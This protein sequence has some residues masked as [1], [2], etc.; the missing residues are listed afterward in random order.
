MN[1]DTY[2]PY[3]NVSFPFKSQEPA[4]RELPPL[5]QGLALDQR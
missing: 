3:I 5:S 1:D 2:S 4:L